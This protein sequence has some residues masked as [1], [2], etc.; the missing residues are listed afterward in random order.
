MPLIREQHRGEWPQVRTLIDRA[1]A[2]SAAA[3][4]LADWVR[5]HGV[6]LSMVA[7]S[8]HRLVGHVMFGRLP[9]RAGDSATD[10]LCL[11]PLSVDPDFRRR[12]IARTL[13]AAALAALADRPEP[14][15]VLEGDPVMYRKFGFR[16]ASQFGVE[17]P[18]E[19]VPEAAFQAVPLR[20]YAGPLRGRLEYPQYFFD[21]GAVGPS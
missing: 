18:S 21:I 9:V 12:G 15:V 16:P 20:G 19:L 11:T 5:E 10:V 8:G 14:L 13:V 6:A 4:L 1:F 3:G 17:P 2:P 7:E